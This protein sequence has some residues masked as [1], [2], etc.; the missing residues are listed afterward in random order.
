M[1]AVAVVY[2]AMGAVGIVSTLILLAVGGPP[3]LVTAAWSVS[4]I[5]GAYYFLRGAIWAKKFLIVISVISATICIAM[6]IP[7]ILLF[8]ETGGVTFFGS[9]TLLFGIGTAYCVYALIFSGPL[10]SEFD[11]RAASYRSAQETARQRFYEE[12]EGRGSGE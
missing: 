7:F 12:F 10:K 11:G 9:L 5:F 4:Y 3:R 1:M 6:S 8:V 2:F